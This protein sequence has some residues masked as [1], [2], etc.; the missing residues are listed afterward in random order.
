MENTTWAPLQKETENATHIFRSEKKTLVC[1]D[2]YTITNLKSIQ[3][4]EFIFTSEVS[5]ASLLPF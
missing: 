1:T 5:H 4:Y 2:K 3:R